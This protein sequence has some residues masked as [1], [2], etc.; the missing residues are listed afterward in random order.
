MVAR[1]RKENNSWGDEKIAENFAKD[2]FRQS[3]RGLRG[4]LSDNL[5]MRG[6]DA[7]SAHG[8]HAL[9]LE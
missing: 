7:Y 6:P 2:K 8:T 5:Q 3:L 9:Y 1:P 4:L